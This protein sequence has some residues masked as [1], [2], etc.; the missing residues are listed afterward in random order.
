[1][2]YELIFA[3]LISSFVGHTALQYSLVIGIYVVF[4][5]IGALFAPESKDR[6]TLW[7]SLAGLELKLIFAAII[8]YFFCFLMVVLI[9]QVFLEQYR[10]FIGVLYVPVVVV[11]FLSGQELPLLFQIYD[12][13]EK[14]ESEG[15]V[16]L[17]D[18][19]ASFLATLLFPLLML[20]FLGV[21]TTL[22]VAVFLNA[23]VVGIA[24]LQ[25]E[26]EMPEKL[27]N[28]VV[29]TSIAITLIGLYSSEIQQ[30]LIDWTF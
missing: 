12:L 13:E 3:H 8:G 26:N 1:M 11:A 24:Q 5:G 6:V 14:A 29:L 21:F 27:K 18:Y 2:T 7:Q 25:L 28:A 4:L 19:L 30:I 15:V 16:L 10:L 20:P 22:V 17:W 9:E 23:F